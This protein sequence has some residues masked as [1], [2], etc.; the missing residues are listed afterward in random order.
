[1]SDE[2]LTFVDDDSEEF[3]SEHYTIVRKITSGMYGE[4]F[5][6]ISKQLSTQ[7]GEQLKVAVKKVSMHGKYYRLHADR[8]ANVL[9]KI[10]HT[11]VVKLL[12][13]TEEGGYTVLLF[14]LCKTDLY[15]MQ[16]NKVLFDLEEVRSI[17]LMTLTGLKAVHDLGIM[18][19]DMKL[20][21]LLLSEEGIIKICDFGLA[22][23]HNECSPLTL[24]IST[25]WYKALEVLLGW[26]QY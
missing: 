23:G 10:S 26:D 4:V 19:R 8:E 15:I 11:N 16:Q 7:N 5:E 24:Q 25:R 20:S 13:S 17:A 18:H 21:N 22:R 12:S 2:L 3:E 1:M 9:S 14:Q 6:G